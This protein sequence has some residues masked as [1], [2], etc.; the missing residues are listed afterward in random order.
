MNSELKQEEEEMSGKK[1]IRFEQQ[2]M[3]IVK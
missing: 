1:R 2:D 3:I